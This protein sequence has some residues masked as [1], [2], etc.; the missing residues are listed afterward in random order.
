MVAAYLAPANRQ[1][2]MAAFDAEASP[3]YDPM[4]KRRPW[5]ADEDEHLKQL[6]GEHGIKSW[7]A[8]SPLASGI[9]M[10]SSAGNG[11]ATT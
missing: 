11:G 7:A 3:E 5:S 10:A 9:E 8:I 1:K 2:T 4:A 6:V